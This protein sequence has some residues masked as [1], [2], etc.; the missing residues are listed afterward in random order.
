M[1]DDGGLPEGLL[2]SPVDGEGVPTR[3]LPLVTG[4]VFRRALKPWW[5]EEIGAPMIGCV[6][7]AG[8]RDVPLPGH[9]HLYIEPDP[10][11]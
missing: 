2:T 4:G 8:W 9:S 1:V 6:R 10:A 7:R 3:R 5:Q 11:M